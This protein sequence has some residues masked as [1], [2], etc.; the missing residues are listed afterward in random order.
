M[1]TRYYVAEAIEGEPHRPPSSP[2]ALRCPVLTAAVLVSGV[3]FF[4]RPDVIETTAA[5]VFYTVTGLTKGTEYQFRVHG[6]NDQGPTGFH[7]DM[8]TD[9]TASDILSVTPDTVPGRLMPR[10]SMRLRSKR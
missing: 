8:D 6:G 4:R 10:L 1:V 3:E 2:V 7:V 5:Q 9:P